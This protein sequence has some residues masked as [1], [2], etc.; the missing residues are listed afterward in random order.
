MVV[1]PLFEQVIMEKANILNQDIDWANLVRHV[2]R[3]Q[4][5]VELSDGSNAIAEIV[6]KKTTILMRDFAAFMGSIPQLGE[7]A[8]SFAKDIESSRRIFTEALDPWES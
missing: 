8:E 4:V 7:D 6:P 3:D 1:Q 5:C 2:A